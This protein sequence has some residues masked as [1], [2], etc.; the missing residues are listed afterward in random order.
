MATFDFSFFGKKSAAR[1]PSKFD[2]RKHRIR[3]TIK[4]QAAERF[5][6]SLTGFGVDSYPEKDAYKKEIQKFDNF[7]VLNM[8]LLALAYIALKHTT[9]DLRQIANPEFLDKIIKLH[10]T[11]PPVGQKLV[12]YKEDLFAYVYYVYQN[13]QKIA[14]TYL[15]NES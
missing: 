8:E 7:E 3:M 10:I 9:F 6:V 2:L 1:A 15:E 13:R 12:K 4:E 14:E 11:D 5:F